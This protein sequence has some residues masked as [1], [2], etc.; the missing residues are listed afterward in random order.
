[1]NVLLT[2]RCNK[3]CSFCFANK[4]MREKPAEDMTLENFSRLIE[5]VCRDRSPQRIQLLGGEPTM[6][7]QFNALLD[8]LAHK[9]LDASLIS[10]LLYTDDSIARC[11]Y[12]AVLAG[13][14]TGGLANAAELDAPDKLQIFRA[15]YAAIQAAFA[16]RGED[17]Y[18]S[19]GITLSRHKSAEAEIAYLE[20]LAENIDLPNLRISLDFQAENVRDEFFINNRDYGRKVL[21]VI[22]KC[23]D[24]RVP[25]SGD[26]KMYPC[27]FEPK[28][29]Q[30]DVLGFT[31]RL[32]TFCPAGNAP[33]D[34]FP[35]MSY[36]HCFPA[37]M[38]AGQNIL[39]FYRLSEAYGEIAFLK[40]TL[41]GLYCLDL[42]AVCQ[43]CSYYQNNRCDSLCLGCQEL[44]TIFAEK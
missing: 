2:T 16:E 44:P 1:M 15:N 10:N 4:V 8:F 43:K 7:P 24:L 3:N 27:M 13:T 32:R 18:M 22:H 36:A 30:K 14:I 9:R 11:V 5:I 33:F 29:F 34:V 35:D 41:Q 21:A 31:Q 20:Y 37:R 12:Q 25:V 19:I 23:L 42:P 17:R 6:H 40:K 28:T 26:C 39:K 38:L